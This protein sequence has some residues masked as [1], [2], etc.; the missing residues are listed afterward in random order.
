MG[1][2]RRM[3]R[4][5][6]PGEPV[7]TEG[8]S[9]DPCSPVAPAALGV[10]HLGVWGTSA[11]V[12][13]QPPSALDSAIA[14]LRQEIAVI[15]RACNRFQ[16]YS[17]LCA[18]NRSGGRPLRVSQT[19][20]EAIEASM[21][22]ASRTDGA[23]DPTVGSTMVAL[24]YDR[25]Y[26]EVAGADPTTPLPATPAPAPGWPSI[27]VNRRARTVQIP[28][29]TQL[30]L[31]ATA[32]AL[33]V[34]RAAQRIVGVTGAAVLVSIGGDVAA[35]GPPPPGGWSIAVVEDSRQQ[36]SPAQQLVAIESGGLASSS[37][38]GRT[39]SRAGWALHHIVDPATGWPVPPMWR[40][41]TVA[42]SS[43]LDANAASTAAMVWGDSAPS[44]LALLGLPARL[45]RHD[46]TVVTVAGWPEVPHSPQPTRHVG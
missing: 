40:L 26:D 32:K 12:S 21:A 27:S 44:R 23:V 19:F 11:T 29:G 25:D 28:S 22:V 36:S 20:L 10:S 15:D 35:L 3:P 31:G 46:A 38:V 14:L 1:T 18:L 45:V 8:A 24:G 6:P 33:C 9:L 13:V 2:R 16:P 34:D 4:R 37:P 17:E 39:W 30:D 5:V 41:V 42:A 43:C 7:A